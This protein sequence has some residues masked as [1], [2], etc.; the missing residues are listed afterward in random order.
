MQDPRAS[1]FL[2]QTLLLSLLLHLAAM[3]SMALVIIQGVPGGGATDDLARVTF[4]AE[5]PLRWQLGWIPWQLCTIIDIVTGLALVWTRWVP[6][7]PALLTLAVTC[8]GAVIEQRGEIPWVTTGAHRAQDALRSGDL[9]S[10]LAFEHSAYRNTAILGA[11]LY[12][13]MVVGWAW[14]LAG[15]QVWNR[16][17]A[18]VLP[19]ALAVLAIGS[20]ALLLPEPV[21]P[22]LRLAGV[23]NGI[24]FVLLEAWLWLACEAV[25]ARSRRRETTGRYAPWVHSASGVRGRVLTTIGKSHVLHAVGSWLPPIALRS[26]ITDVVYVNYLVDAERLAGHVPE[27]FELC[28]V[29]PDGSH[30]LFSILVFRQGH[31]GPAA[32]GPL[33]RLFPSPVETNWRTYV[34]DPRTGLDGVYFTTNAVESTL[35][36]LVARHLSEGMPMHVL[37]NADLD[38]GESGVTRVRLDPGVGTAPDLDAHLA[39]GRP[40][41]PGSDWS[42]AFGDWDGFLAACVPQERAF[43]SQPW[44]RSTTRQEIRFA[45]PL[46][47]FEP[48]EGEVISRAARAI[49]GEAEPVCFRVPTVAF[50]FDHVVRERLAPEREVSRAS[51]S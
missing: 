34:H 42:A 49:V 36:S 32:L 15:G 47:S 17:L 33:R 46:E 20:A 45:I 13:V 14:C 40:R 6:R 1:R 44:T 48:L 5:H 23:A 9:G 8:A 43:S 22:G 18:R 3:A 35:V 16:A 19:P 31:F 2:E 4:V 39:P 7:I 11:S 24:G 25:L 37:A 30:G 38:V 51:G 10:Y 50:R 28:T 26:D 41:L 12:L 27:G 29:G 21:R